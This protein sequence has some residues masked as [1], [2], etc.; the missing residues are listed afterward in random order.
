MTGLGFC[1]FQSFSWSSFSCL[2]P[3]KFRSVLANQR[4]VYSLPTIPRCPFSPGP[5]CWPV[6]QQ[7]LL[8][9]PRPVFGSASASVSGWGR[10]GHGVSR[11]RAGW[12]GLKGGREVGLWW[13][14][15]PCFC[16]LTVNFFCLL[17]VF[18]YCFPAISLLGLFPQINT[19][20]IYLLEQIDM[21]FFGGS[22]KSFTFCSFRKKVS[23]S[24]KG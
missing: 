4:P 8:L 14:L 1:T 3:P 7:P 21:L 10:R 19:F 18:L 23:S 24:D 6:L 20:C 2:I 15:G 16:V 22:G 5:A 11:T 9:L 12:T 17:S 13:N